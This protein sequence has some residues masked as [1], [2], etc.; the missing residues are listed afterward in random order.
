MMHAALRREER[1]RVL[2]AHRQ[3]LADILAFEQDTQ[4]LWIEAFAAADIAEHLHVGQETHF[5]ALHALTLASFA[6][7]ACGIEGKAARGEAT[8]ARLGCIRIEAAN[9]IPES[10]ISRGAGARRFADGGLID[11]EHPADRLPAG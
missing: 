10:D 9:G 1:Q 2:D 7:A 4:G 6:A 3:Y 8:H 5:D 11:L